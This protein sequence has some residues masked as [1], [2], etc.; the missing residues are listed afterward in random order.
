MALNLLAEYRKR[1]GLTQKQVGDYIGISS[2]AVSKWENGQSEPDVRSLCKLAQLYNT[3]VDELVGNALENGEDQRKKE[4]KSTAFK[5]AIKR[6]KKTIT[7]VSS[8]ILVVLAA[9]IAFLL[10]RTLF[11][12]K[13]AYKKYQKIELGMTMEEVEAILGKPE[14]T[15]DTH[16]D[17]DS[18]DIGDAI[19]AGFDWAQYGHLNADF[20]YYRGPEYDKNLEADLEGNWNYDFQ[21]YYQIRIT[22]NQ[23]GK[24]IEAYFNTKTDYLAYDDYGSNE[25]KT[26]SS[27]E[28][29]DG[30]H[31]TTEGETTEKIRLYFEDGSAYLGELEVLGEYGDFSAEHPWGTLSLGYT[32][33]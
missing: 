13:I 7:L 16:Y 29:L 31:L 8:I 9:T 11:D 33:D 23:Y 5:E 32:S 2:Q 27:F 1:A 19:S 22:F 20:W 12:D 17:E 21:S 4:A 6:N 14:E 26:L 10:L 25:D 28:Y 18:S 3:T 24:V 15:K 30:S